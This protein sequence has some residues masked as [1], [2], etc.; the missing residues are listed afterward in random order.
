MG[1]ALLSSVGF[2]FEMVVF[3]KD[4]DAYVGYLSE[5]KVLFIDGELK[6]DSENNRIQILP[7]KI[8]S[9]DLSEFRSRNERLIA[10]EAAI[11][12]KD[13]LDR[14]EGAYLIHVPV[15]AT[16]D[17]LVKLKQYLSS[18]APGETLVTLSI[19]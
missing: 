1:V 8:I 10:H 5:G 16:R 6:I 15:S 3:P 19:R 7:K 12:E 9:Q 17:D 11:K 2:E 14:G 18:C 4:Y 13:R